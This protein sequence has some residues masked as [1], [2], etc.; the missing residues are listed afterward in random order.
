MRQV[1]QSS[2]TRAI[3]DR[4][5]PQILSYWTRR[6]DHIDESVAQ[7]SRTS[8]R[9]L[10]ALRNL[11]VIVNAERN[12]HP[13]PFLQQPRSTPHPANSRATEQDIRA[14]E[15]TAGVFEP[16]RQIVIR[17]EAFAEATKL[18][19]ES[20]NHSEANGHE[21]ANLELQGPIAFHL[22]QK[23]SL[24]S[25]LSQHDLDAVPLRSGRAENPE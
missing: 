15:Q 1:I 2:G 11:N 17:F 3:H 22:S 9:K 7:Q 13:F 23:H 12:R 5:F 10:T 25:N 4:I 16:D 19:H 6:R 8:H 18:D 24:N 14:L 20:R 21:N